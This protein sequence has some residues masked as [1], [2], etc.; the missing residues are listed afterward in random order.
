MGIIIRAQWEGWKTVLT[1][2]TMEKPNVQRRQ[3]HR[4]CASAATNR[5]TAGDAQRMSTK[6]PGK[7]EDANQQES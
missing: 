3:L 7:K 1:P 4:A 5:T 2:Q 6:I